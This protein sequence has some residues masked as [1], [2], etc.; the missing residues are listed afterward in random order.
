MGL[1]WSEDGTGAIQEG[2]LMDF[3]FVFAASFI[4]NCIKDQ[5]LDKSGER[6][7][8]NT[9]AVVFQYD[10][11][12]WD[13]ENNKKIMKNHVK[14]AAKMTCINLAPFLQWRPPIR[15]S[16][17]YSTGLKGAAA[18]NLNSRQGNSY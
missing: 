14:M 1:F 9:K 13:S 3:A 11:R 17:I 6:P 10:F 16:S 2:I 15:F 18:C 8:G 12:F 5:P 7:S 4:P